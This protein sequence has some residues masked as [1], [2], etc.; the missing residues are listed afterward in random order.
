MVNESGATCSF[1]LQNDT[2]Y[3]FH[4]INT[5][6]VDYKDYKSS[7]DFVGIRYKPIYNKKRWNTLLCP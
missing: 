3:A 7:E 6:V 5:M 1:E 4:L 2:Y